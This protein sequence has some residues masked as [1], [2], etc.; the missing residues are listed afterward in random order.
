MFRRCITRLSSDQCEIEI[1]ADVA[2]VD[3]IICADTTRRVDEAYDLCA[4]HGIRAHDI[5][6]KV[7][8][9]GYT[10]DEF[11]AGRTVAILRQRA[12]LDPCEDLTACAE[13]RSPRR[14]WRPKTVIAAVRTGCSRTRHIIFR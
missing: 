1:V 5:V 6:V 14:L 4:K 2:G 13:Q 7:N 10:L 3:A 11:H 8:N 12:G 9:R